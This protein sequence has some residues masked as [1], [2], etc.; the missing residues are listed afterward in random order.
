MRRFM[1]VDQMVECTY[2]LKINRVFNSSMWFV[3]ANFRAHE[4]D[5]Q[6]YLV[7]F[8]VAL[9]YAILRQVYFFC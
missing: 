3:F 5:P 1:E 8:H 9:Q 7:A 2:R 6:D 4:K